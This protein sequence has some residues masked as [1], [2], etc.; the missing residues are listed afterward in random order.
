[1]KVRVGLVLMVAMGAM[2]LSGCQRSAKKGEMAEIT[3]PPPAQKTEGRPG[4]SA[5]KPQSEGPQTRTVSTRDPKTGKTV[6]KQVP[7]TTAV[8]ADASQTRTVRTRDPQTG[9]TITKQ[10]PVESSS[11]PADKPGEFAV[12]WTE[13][14][15]VEQAFNATNRMLYETLGLGYTYSG[16]HSVKPAMD[17]ISA[18]LRARSTINVE[19]DVSIFLVSPEKTSIIVKATS[20]TQ[21]KH[22]LEK[23]TLYLRSKINEALANEPETAAA[24][25][26]PFPQTMVF[27]GSVDQVYNR[28]CEWV[29][30]EGLN[31]SDRNRNSGSRGGDKFYKYIRCGSFSGITFTFHVRK[32][33]S[34]RVQL[35]VVPENYKDQA[36]FSVIYESLEK[37]LDTL[38]SG[39]EEVVESHVETRTVPDAVAVVMDRLRS[40]AKGY[41]LDWNSDRQDG[42]Y[43]RADCS[44]VSGIRFSFLIRRVARDETVVEIRADRYSGKDE[45]PMVLTSLEKVLAALEKPAEAVEN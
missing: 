41:G 27:E 2:L 42:F 10:V 28:L 20:Q 35:Q 14:C 36:E 38:Q 34:S 25:I 31:F 23:H 26:S 9:R 17:Q 21:P 19:F 5:A 12:T 8:S 44:T 24:E 11:A 3:A 37:V 16:N 32:V 13:T 7:V 39:R 6:T 30:A 4:C 18:T 1:M 29:D 22:I 40:W 45:F 15:S 33:S 43:A